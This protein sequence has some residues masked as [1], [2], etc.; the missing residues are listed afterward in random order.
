MAVT[1][2]HFP[3]T[4][5]LGDITKLKLDE[6]EPV[7]IICAGSPC[8][9]LSVA[10]KRKGL[11]GERSGLFKTAV[12]LVHEMRKRTNGQY[13]RFFCWE[14]V[15]GAFSSNKGADFR[16]VLEKIGEAEV[17]MPTNGRWSNAGMVKLP[18]CEIAWRVLDAQYFGVPQRRRRI[19]L[20][21]DFAESDR[22]AAEIL[23]ERTGVSGDFA[24]SGD[25]RKEVTDR[26][27]ESTG[28]T[29]KFWDGS[30]VASTLTATGAGGTHLSPDRGNFVGVL[31]QIPFNISAYNSNSM[32][33][34]NPN[35]GIQKVETSRTLDLNGGNPACNQGGLMITEKV[36]K[37]IAIQGSMIG[38]KDENGPQGSGISE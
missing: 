23:F 7:D 25:K 17:P 1:A 26:A 34:D 8:Q 5:Q 12:A 36:P 3:E 27:R 29:S 31:E 18:K 33:S 2:K 14:N 11:D 9:D 16:V 15:Y 28:S 22:C 32:L 19:F 13:P 30:E 21:A 38:R 24:E 20:V 4:K 35:S 6:I 37:A 10:G